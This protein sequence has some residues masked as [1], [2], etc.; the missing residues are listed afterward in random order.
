MSFISLIKF[1]ATYIAYKYNTFLRKTIVSSIHG[2]NPYN[3][4]LHHGGR[5]G[6]LSFVCWFIVAIK[7]M[8]DKYKVK[9]NLL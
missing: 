3:I 5:G 1:V 2:S 8:V 7:I 4:S 9:T 6:V